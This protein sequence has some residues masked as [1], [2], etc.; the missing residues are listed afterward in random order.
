[1]DRVSTSINNH[2][3]HQQQLSEEEEENE[4]VQIEYLDKLISIIITTK[5]E[6]NEIIEKEMVCISII[7]KNNNTEPTNTMMATVDV[8]VVEVLEKVVNAAVAVLGQCCLIDIITTMSMMT[9]KQKEEEEEDSGYTLKRICTV[10]QKLMG[11]DDDDDQHQEEHNVDVTTTTNKNNITRTISHLLKCITSCLLEY[12]QLEYSGTI[13]PHHNHNHPI[14]HPTLLKDLCAFYL[15]FIINISQDKIDDASSSKYRDEISN[16][17]GL[18]LLI[19]PTMTMSHLIRPLVHHHHDHD[20][21]KDIGQGGGDSNGGGRRW[22]YVISSI[23]F[24][25]ITLLSSSIH[26]HT[27]GKHYDGIDRE[28]K[29][30]LLSSLDITEVVGGRGWYN[31][32][33]DTLNIITTLINQYPTNAAARYS[34]FTEDDIT[35][36]DIQ[37]MCCDLLGRRLWCPTSITTRTTR[38]DRTILENEIIT[39]IGS[40]IQVIY[41]A[42]VNLLRR[43]ERAKQQQKQKEDSRES[44]SSSS[45][46]KEKPCNK[47][48]HI[49]VE[50]TRVINDLKA[51]MRTVYTLI[52]IVSIKTRREVII[53][54]EHYHSH[55]H[56]MTM[57]YDDDDQQQLQEFHHTVERIY[58]HPICRNIIISIS[59]AATTTTTTTST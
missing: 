43:L 5:R 33:Y 9:S 8:V 22:S 46:K 38:D 4:E 44:S 17:M 16:T 31:I 57:Q 47:Q 54:G 41:E 37:G 42:I 2:K 25:V 26:H 23:R 12:T 10:I 30:M 34:C 14:A 6:H 29:E 50:Y 59:R 52:N 36:E 40:I 49:G 39:N 55:D 45:S 11:D 7:M 21:Q 27:Y 28:V 35:K 53:Q 19:S 3:K 15:T 1:M 24:Y 18:L 48:Q 56:T 20:H 32:L 58:Q 51:F 13:S